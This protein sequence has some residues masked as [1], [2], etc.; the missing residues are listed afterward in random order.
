MT[1]II[2]GNLYFTLWWKLLATLKLTNYI[3]KF[4]NS[5]I[6]K[7]SQTNYIQKLQNNKI[8]MYKLQNRQN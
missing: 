7:N 4:K 6:F 8:E 3:Q 2:F 1:N 5:T